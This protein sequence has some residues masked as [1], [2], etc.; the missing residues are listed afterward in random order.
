MDIVLPIKKGEETDK[1]VSGVI[2]MVVVGANGAGKSRFG[3]EIEK[4]YADKTFRISALKSVIFDIP[5]MYSANLPILIATTIA[6]IYSLENHAIF[7]CNYHAVTW[8]QLC[9][10]S[11]FT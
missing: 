4:R 7:L 6:K 10:T 9:F 11:Y 8:K 3:S 5:P 1:V 2:T